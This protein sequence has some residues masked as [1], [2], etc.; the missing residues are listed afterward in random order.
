VA[1][2]GGDDIAFAR[3]LFAAT[4][5]T[6]LPGSYLSREAHGENPGRGF[7]RMALVSTMDETLEA[8]SR[9]RDFCT[10]RARTLAPSAQ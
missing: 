6:V 10:Q 4:H 2:P 5:V 7:V 1:V 8:A 9:I 3:E